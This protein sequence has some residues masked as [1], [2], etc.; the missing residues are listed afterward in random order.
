MIFPAF[1]SIPLPSISKR[2]GNLSSHLAAS[3]E[4]YLSRSDIPLPLRSMNSIPS[5]SMTA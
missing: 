5:S 4:P 2:L 3:R 1:S